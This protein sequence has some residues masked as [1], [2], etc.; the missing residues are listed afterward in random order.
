M[1]IRLAPLVVQFNFFFGD[2]SVISSRSFSLNTTLKQ[3]RYE[4]KQ[5]LREYL[6]V[7]LRKKIDMDVF[8][9]DKNKVIKNFSVRDLVVSD[10]F[11]NLM[12]GV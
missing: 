10:V 1:F 9:D 4:T 3:N 12:G 8:C 5:V 11:F 2:Y 6:N 7:S